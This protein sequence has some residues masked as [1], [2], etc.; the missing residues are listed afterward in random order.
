MIDPPP[1]HRLATH[2]HPQLDAMLCP[3]VSAMPAVVHVHRSS[4]AHA[5]LTAG[6]SDLWQTE[7]N[8]RVAIGIPTIDHADMIR[9]DVLALAAAGI[10]AAL[11]GRQQLPAFTVTAAG[12]DTRGVRMFG[13]LST[14]G[15]RGG[16]GVAAILDEVRTI[17]GTD[18]PPG[19]LYAVLRDGQRDDVADLLEAMI[20]RQPGSRLLRYARY[21]LDRR[22]EALRPGNALVDLTQ[23]LP[24]MPAIEQALAAR[25]TGAG[26][27]WPEPFR[28]LIQ[29]FD[30]LRAVVAAARHRGARPLPS[31]KTPGSSS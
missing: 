17:T 11:D 19:A 23:T 20:A 25:A 26:R 10:S 16:P 3:T 18:Y 30:M 31:G 15:G 8:V 14:G 21:R 4:L 28:R 1:L 7:D 5:G 13:L 29:L 9:S 22:P 6:W 24:G 2:R 12:M 27:Q